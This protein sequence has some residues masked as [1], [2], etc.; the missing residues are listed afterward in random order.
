MGAAWTA[1]RNEMAVSSF[2]KRTGL[3]RTEVVVVVH[4]PSKTAFV[5]WRHAVPESIREVRP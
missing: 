3:A 2:C 4:A 1:L 5:Q